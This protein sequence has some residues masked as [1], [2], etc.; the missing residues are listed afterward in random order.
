MFIQFMLVISC[1]VLL[2]TNDTTGGIGVDCEELTGKAV[3]ILFIGNTYTSQHNIPKMLKDITCSK[4]IKTEVYKVTEHNSRFLDHDSNAD[5]DF[6]IK[7]KK[8]DYIILQNHGQVPSWKEN[9][10]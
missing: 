2:D 3:N 4:G 7:K 5:T 8:W 10:T 1:N 9:A 6:I